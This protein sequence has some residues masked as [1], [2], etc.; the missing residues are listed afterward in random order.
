MSPADASVP[1]DDRITELDAMQERDIGLSEPELSDAFVQSGAVFDVEPSRNGSAE[2][3]VD[4]GDD[5]HDR[6]SLDAVSIFRITELNVPSMLAESEVFGCEMD[7]E[8]GG[9]GLSGAFAILGTSLS[10]QLTSSVEDPESLKLF[11]AF[12]ESHAQPSSVAEV[13]QELIFFG[14]TQWQTV[15]HG[16]QNYAGLPQTDMRFA[17]SFDGERFT[18]THGGVTLDTGPLRHPFNVQL[19]HAR[20]HGRVVRSER[21]LFISEAALTGYLTHSAII[22]FIVGL[23][24]FCNEQ[25]ATFC[26]TVARFLDADP[27]TSELD[28]DTDDLAQRVVLPLMRNLDARV[29]GDAVTHCDHG[30]EDAECIACNAVS[31][32]FQVRSTPL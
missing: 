7:S 32:C 2:Q 12:L 17:V 28:G 14:G 19:A 8:N 5:A 15:D 21:G 30:C 9:T 3:E 16:T 1:M 25:D 20:I 22:D 26:R 18:S 29:D 27:T 4:D 6:A 31:V 11:A 13:G 23:Q 24:S 10:E